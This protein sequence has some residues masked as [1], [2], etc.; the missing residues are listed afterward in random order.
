MQRHHVYLQQPVE[1]DV[2]I[3]RYN[4]HTPRH[5]THPNA[6]A[7]PFDEALHILREIV[8]EPFLAPS[9]FPEEGEGKPTYIS[10]EHHQAQ[11]HQFVS[12]CRHAG[13][14]GRKLR[15]QGCPPKA[16]IDYNPA[17]SHIFLVEQHAER[18]AHQHI[19]QIKQYD[20]GNGDIIV[21]VVPVAAVEQAPEK[22]IRR[23]RGIGSRKH[24]LCPAVWT[25]YRG[26]W[27]L[28]K[29]DEEKYGKVDSPLRTVSVL[30]N[31]IA[32]YSC[33]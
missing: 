29:C 25:V 19:R 5:E 9:V 21:E 3:H 33:R 16:E 27:S 20:V 14:Q 13:Q 15:Q 8:V 24:P 32:V 2:G 10:H 18:V 6:A 12:V 31:N 23:E 4:R 28:D 22:K 26:M 17:A 30:Q 7:R 1:I 11:E